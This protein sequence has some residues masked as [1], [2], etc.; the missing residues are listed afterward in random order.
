VLSYA[1][2]KV[3]TVLIKCPVRRRYLYFTKV[4]FMHLISILRSS[5]TSHSVPS[6]RCLFPTC[7]QRK[8]VMLVMLVVQDMLPERNCVFLDHINKK[9]IR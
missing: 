7:G 4:S 2:K 6:F 5:S 1:S 8:P 9:M 3:R